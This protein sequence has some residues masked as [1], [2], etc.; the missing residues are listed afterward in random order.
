M[1]GVR[2]L[3]RREE[4]IRGIPCCAAVE[5]V[6]ERGRKRTG[7]GARAGAVGVDEDR[8]VALREAE[9]LVLSPVVDIVDHISGVQRHDELRELDVLVVLVAGNRARMGQQHFDAV[10]GEHP[11]RVVLGRSARRQRRPVARR[12]AVGRGE[13]VLEL[14]ADGDLGKLVVIG[15]R[16]LRLEDHRLRPPESVYEKSPGH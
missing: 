9:C 13:V 5:E 15:V 1:L 2:E 12:R 11:D 14:P 6:D 16:R 7:L 8:A 3:V 10:C 4:Q